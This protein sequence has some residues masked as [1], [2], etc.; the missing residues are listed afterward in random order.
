MLQLDR[1]QQRADS[2]PQAAE[3]KDGSIADLIDFAF[4]FLRRRVLLIVAVLLAIVPVGEYLALKLVPAYFAAT[5]TVII[6]TRKYQI[7]QHTTMVGDTMIDAAAVESQ[8]EI[9]KSE[10]VLLEVIRKLHLA[11][12]PE[13]G[14]PVPGLLGSL[15]LTSR[16]TA[17]EYDRERRALS[18][19]WR[20]LT[21]RRIGPTYVIEITYRSANAER[22]AEVANTV[23]EVYISEQLE[24]K[25]DDTRRAST[26]LEGRLKELSDQAADAQRAV[27]EFKGKNNIVDAGNGRLMYEQQLTELN[28]QIIPARERTAE[29]AARLRRVEE[30]L[31]SDSEDATINSAVADSLKSDVVTK[32]RT[33]Y[34]EL[35]NREV[36]W[37]ARYGVNH[38]AVVNL[39]NQMHQIRNSLRD[40]LKRVAE[41]YKSEYDIAKQHE[42]SLKHDLSS[43]TS[44]IET[45]NQARVT[46]G[47]LESTAQSYR[48][49][50]D[51]FLQRY[52]ESVQQQ[53]FPIT[54]A[55]LITKATPSK[56]KDY[57]KTLVAAAAVPAGA[58]M[59]GI[60][61]AFLF[62][63]MDRA[64]RSGKQAEA[65]LQTNC[66][67]LIPLLD[68]AGKKKRS[69]FKRNTNRAAAKTR[70]IVRGTS[71]VWHAVDQPFSLLS[72]A[73]RSIKLAVDQQC[74]DTCRVI[75]LT[76]SLPDEGK[77]TVALS[78]AEGIALAGS[79]VI[80]VDCDLRHP[81][82]ST[83]LSP[84]AAAG[85]VDVIA[86]AATL[87]DAIWKDPDTGMAFLP[88]G[89]STPMARSSEILSSAATKNVLDLLRD[90][91]E[92]VVVDL[93]PLVPVVDVRATSHLVDCYLLVVEW[94]RTR[95]EMVQRALAD[96]P[97]VYESLL[98]LVLNKTDLKRLRGYDATFSRLYGQGYY[99]GGVGAP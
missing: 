95:V 2:R 93:S 48:A 54:E 22:A 78:L 6:D 4:G 9:L 3:S 52:M 32:L 88:A 10:N 57:R 94:G 51:N 65:A 67:A 39:R 21:I 44:E 62:D 5:A 33:Q 23:G 40:E 73:I 90:Q 60:A 29:A 69:W 50:Y 30:I 24:G 86:G 68:K 61:L 14:R 42:E 70:T 49:L 99:Y 56:D 98:G 66:L 35:A 89:A 37:S 46:L 36:E 27:V 31:N 74:G 25:Y 11:D 82:L 96:A 1:S 47:E 85:F 72:E 77:S 19:L 64:I 84:D 7:F 80:L 43:V 97:S 34:L 59:L 18:V 53:T 63:L 55:R 58:L 12:D 26:W 38:L 92:Y 76:S 83:M 71:P 13:F 81:S 20:Q 91:Y 8:L 16:G 17:S 28:A 15:L 41:T 45:A 79:R 75:G 87:G